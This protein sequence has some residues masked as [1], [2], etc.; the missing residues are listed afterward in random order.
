MLAL[1]FPAVLMLHR[2]AAFAVTGATFAAH[3]HEPAARAAPGSH[4]WIIRWP[5]KLARRGF[6]QDLITG[7]PVAVGGA[8]R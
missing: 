4:A 6:G 8:R 3:P 2:L 1:R 7:E 5:R